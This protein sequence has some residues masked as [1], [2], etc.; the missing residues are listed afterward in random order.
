MVTDADPPQT[1]GNEALDG[2]VAKIVGGRMAT[3][4]IYCPDHRMVE[5]QVEI[6]DAT[7]MRYAAMHVADAVGA[8][9]EDGVWQLITRG[10]QSIDP[11]DLA[12]DWDGKEV[13]LQSL[14]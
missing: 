13:V 6:Q 8:D 12:A 2:K 14:Q 10:F 4:H 7:T 9:S 1:P 5:H 11:D 3:L